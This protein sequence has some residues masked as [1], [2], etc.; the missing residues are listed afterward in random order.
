MIELE[1]CLT[2]AS[3]PFVLK[4]LVEDQPGKVASK[5]VFDLKKSC[6]PSYFLLD[7][8]GLRISGQTLNSWLKPAEP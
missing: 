4:H 1:N 3:A 6:W 7:F 2:Q 8:L 5:Q